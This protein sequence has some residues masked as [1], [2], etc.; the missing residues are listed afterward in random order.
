MKYTAERRCW[1][2]GRNGTQD[3]LD[4]HHIFGGSFRDKSEKLG[5]VVDL[6]H[7]DCHIFGQN[8]VHRNKERM[9][10]LHE[11]GQRMAMERFG[12]DVDDFRREFGKNYLPEEED[13]TP[14]ETVV[15][16]FAL[17]PDDAQL[18]W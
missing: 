8:A 13:E 9:R 18:P 16:G 11:Y 6:C 1:L 4:K 7:H 10:R 2:C 12:W 3:A 14:A 15:F 5:L 17:V